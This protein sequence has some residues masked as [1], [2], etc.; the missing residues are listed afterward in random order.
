MIGSIGKKLAAALLC[1]TAFM[2][3]AFE[4]HAAETLKFGAVYPTRNVIGTQAVAGAQLAVKMI[5]DAGGVL[6]R[7]LEFVVYDSN[8]SPVDGV[9]GMQRLLTADGIRYIAGVVSST[10]ALATIPV[11]ESEGALAVFAIPKHPDVTASGYDGIF[12][13]NSTTA[14]D[15]ASFNGYLAD[16]VAPEKVTML[17]ENSDFGLLSNKNMKALFGDKLVLTETFEVHQ[18]DFSAIASNAWGSGADLVC[19]AISNPEQTANVLRAMADLGYKPERCIM[20]GLLNS[21]LPRL[22]G[23]AAEGVFSEDVYLPSID[24]ELNR[25][26]VS[27]YEAS[28]GVT[29]GKIEVLAFEAV[30]ALAKAIEIAG[31]ADNLDAVKNALKTNEFEVLRGKVHFDETGQAISGTQYRIEVRDGKVVERK[32]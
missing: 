11:I 18:A 12:R 31:D 14:I 32:D 19:M 24:N 4:A 22:A 17:G 23:E 16:V 1:A 28:E 27:A 29:P 13:M 10:V 15:A 26:F 25:K 3:H 7:P 9:A 20:P 8:F 5:N 2:P 21:D 6:G 30:W